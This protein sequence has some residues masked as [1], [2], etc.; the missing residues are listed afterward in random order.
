[1][2]MKRIID[3]KD[4]GGDDHNDNNNGKS[5]TFHYLCT[6]KELPAG[7]SR[8]FLVSNYKELKSKSLYSTWMANTIVYPSSANI[9]EGH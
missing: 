7:K 5:S 8:Q 6:I 2:D 1:M 4:G 9:K 3:Y